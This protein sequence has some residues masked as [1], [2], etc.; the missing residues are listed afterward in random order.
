MPSA[1]YGI[2]RDP[3]WPSESCEN[4][5]PVTRHN[6]GLGIVAEVMEADIAQASAA[7]DARPR[8]LDAHEGR[9]RTAAAGDHVEA[10]F[11]ARRRGE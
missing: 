8:A 6:P 7:A 9:I 2:G 10:A 3:P 11:E 5:A 4:R 1:A